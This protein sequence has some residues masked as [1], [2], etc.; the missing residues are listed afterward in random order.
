MHAFSWYL[1]LEFVP[2]GDV[3]TFVLEH[4]KLE[5][6]KVAK[7]LK[8]LFSA[9]SHFH[10]SD[11]IH[12]DLKPS[13]V[14][15]SAGRDLLKIIDFGLAVETPG[16]AID[17]YGHAGTV[18]FMAPEV[19][20]RQKYGKAVDVFSL[21]AIAFFMLS[22][23]QAFAGAEVDEIRAQNTTGIAHFSPTWDNRKFALSR[24]RVQ[25]LGLA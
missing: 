11:I 25:N 15:I 20:R 21:G 1:M 10:H 9:V 2:G 22:G 7:Y 12:R 17:W 5:P 8:Q 16:G 23:E 4:G 14:L 13:N 3:G 19:L 18:G 24:T 6:A